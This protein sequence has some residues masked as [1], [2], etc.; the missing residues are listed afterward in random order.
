VGTQ[1]PFHAQRGLFQIKVSCLVA[2]AVIYLLEFIQ[3]DIDQP[4]DPSLFSR[5][6]DLRVQ[7]PFQGEPVVNLGE[8]VELRTMLQVGLEPTGF[9]SQRGEPGSH[10]ESFCLT[11][12]SGF[13]GIK[14]D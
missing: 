13:L 10:R 3:V 1:L 12:N 5:H 11:G 8:K 9:Y 7:I 14:S 2:V 6:F 4:E